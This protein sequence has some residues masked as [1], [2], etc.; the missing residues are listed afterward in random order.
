LRKLFIATSEW[1]A[2]FMGVPCTSE[3]LGEINELFGTV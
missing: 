2:Q 1:N 3:R